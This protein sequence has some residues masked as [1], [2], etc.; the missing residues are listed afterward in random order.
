MLD[1]ASTD[2][3]LR[4]LFSASWGLAL[5]VPFEALL[6]ERG[7]PVAFEDF[8]ISDQDQRRPRARVALLLRRPYGRC[9]RP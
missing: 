6:V 8:A 3:A 7:D 2:S 5:R 9:R 1:I 4:A